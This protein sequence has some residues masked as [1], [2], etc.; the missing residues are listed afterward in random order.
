MAM[1]DVEAHLGKGAVALFMQGF[2]GDVQPDL[3]AGGSFYVSD[4]VEVCRLGRELAGCAVEVLG[5]VMKRVPVC[6]LVSR[7]MTL[8]LQLEEREER[9]AF[10]M[11]Y[12]RLAEGL[13]FLTANAEP[14]TAYGLFLKQEVGG[15]IL[16]LGYT[17]GMIGYI[18]TANQIAEGGY[19]PLES[20]PYF[21][22]PAPFVPEIEEQIQQAIVE[23]V[24]ASEGEKEKGRD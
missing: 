11:T 15:G 3:V 18:P 8:E 7:Q 14:V 21:R 20:L 5:G 23:L 24:G 22:L 6:K 17:N 2:C 19:E 9:V 12:C 10:E 1:N 13:S 4:D 16:P